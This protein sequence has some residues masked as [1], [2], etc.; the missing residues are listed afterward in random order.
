M[1]ETIP[2]L[3]INFTHMNVRE[4]FLN[5]VGQTSDAPLCLN[6]VKAEGSN[7]WDADGKKYIDLIGGVSVCNVGHRHPAV[8]AAIK[9]QADEYLVLL[10]PSFQ[11]E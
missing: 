5:N 3:T 11:G 10:F 8:V 7:M 1:I 9:K 6:I 2:K 4:L